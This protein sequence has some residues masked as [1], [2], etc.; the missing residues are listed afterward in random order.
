MCNA[1]HWDY[2]I[3]GSCRVIYA[4]GKEETVYAG[5][6]FYT[7]PIHTFIVD[8]SIKFIDISPDE[9]FRILM[10]QFTKNLAAIQT[11]N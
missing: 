3:D 4:D 9:E 2:I 5:E 7:P 11:S 1:R 8:K 10:D 6:V